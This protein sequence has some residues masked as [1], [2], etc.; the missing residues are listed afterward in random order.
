MLPLSGL[1]C[2]WSL[3][4]RDSVLCW[5]PAQIDRVHASRDWEKADSWIEMSH[6]TPPLRTIFR[7]FAAIFKFR[8]RAFKSVRPVPRSRSGLT[9]CLHPPAR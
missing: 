2:S 5:D 1:T 8:R 7:G 4:V 3:G 6:G 9:F